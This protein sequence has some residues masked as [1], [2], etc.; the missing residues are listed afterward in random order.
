MEEYRAWGTKKNYGKE[1][2]GVI[3]ST[4]IIDKGGKIFNSWYGV[5]VEGHIDKVLTELE[6]LD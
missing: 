6:R 2:E 5:K 4:F 3:R 1:N